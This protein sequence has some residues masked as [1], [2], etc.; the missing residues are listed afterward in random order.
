MTIA[1]Q[2]RAARS[3]IGGTQEM[4]AFQAGISVSTLKRAEGSIQPPASASAIE[5]I[6]EALMSR[7]VQ[8]IDDNR[9]GPG[10]RLSKKVSEK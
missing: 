4:I 6:R 10:V 3:L 7:G 8:F 9:G 2:I 1:S 5:K